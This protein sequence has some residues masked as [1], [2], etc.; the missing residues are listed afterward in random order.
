MPTVTRSTSYTIDHD[1]GREGCGR[2]ELAYNDR[3][4]LFVS[5]AFFEGD[6]A[7]RWIIGRDI[8]ARRAP[9][10]ADVQVS[11]DGVWTVLRLVGVTETA[12][13]RIMTAQ[14]DAFLRATTGLVPYGREVLSFDAEL[15]QLLK[16]GVR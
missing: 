6:V 11:V 1:D 2:V 15:Y 4:P 13:V 14:I 8:L 16:R 10:L 5:V 9:G 3:H 12:A 7:E